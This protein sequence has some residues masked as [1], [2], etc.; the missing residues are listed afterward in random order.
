MPFA[1]MI[2]R[3]SQSAGSQASQLSV[4]PVFAVSGAQDGTSPP[5]QWNEPLWQA[6]AGNSNYPGPPNGGWAGSSTYW[7][8]EDPSLGHDVWD[9]YRDFTTSA[10]LPM[11]DWLFSQGN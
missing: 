8:L 5:P 6:L 3:D 1:G 9:T 7:Y 10:P 11:Y 4:V 2:T